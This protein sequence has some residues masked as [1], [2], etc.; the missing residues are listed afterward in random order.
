MS[1]MNKLSVGIRWCHYDV[2]YEDEPLCTQ[3]HSDYVSILK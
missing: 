1:E 3:E 2:P